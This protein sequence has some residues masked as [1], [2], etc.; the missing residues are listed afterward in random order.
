M[1][2]YGA[3]IRDVPG[4]LKSLTCR[5]SAIASKRSMPR[6][7]R[8]VGIANFKDTLRWL[9]LGTMPRCCRWPMSI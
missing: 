5:N 2:P 9:L 8:V 3:A 1:N 6:V 4:P 7:Q